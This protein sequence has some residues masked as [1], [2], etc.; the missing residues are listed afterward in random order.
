MSTTPQSTATDFKLEAYVRYLAARGL[1]KLSVDTYLSQLQDYLD[2]RTREGT[3]DEETMNTWLAAAA[4]TS[5]RRVRSVALRHYYDMLHMDIV[6]PSVRGGYSKPTFPPESETVSVLEAALKTAVTKG[7]APLLAYY[8]MADC[9]LRVNEVVN[10]KPAHINTERRELTVHAGK[11]GKNRIV[12]MSTRLLNAYRERV[13]DIEPGQCLTGFNNRHSITSV[14]RRACLR[15][16][17]PIVSPHQLRHY[18]ASQ[19][20]DNG[21]DIITIGTMLGHSN[22]TTTQHYL[23]RTSSH[24]HLAYNNT[25]A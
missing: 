24:L 7:T 2:T 12:P 11:G 16:H 9:G 22:I 4:C 18:F 20:L 23:H 14:L 8:L 17:Q 13:P 21:V 19:L 10:I 3:T 15:T 1:A 6:V 5:T 25:F